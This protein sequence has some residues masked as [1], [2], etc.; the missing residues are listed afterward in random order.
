[1]R[2]WLSESTQGFV[3]WELLR[4]RNPIPTTQVLGFVR[5]WRS[6]ST[7]GFLKWEFQTFPWKGVVGLDVC[8]YHRTRASD[9]AS[10]AYD[11]DVVS[12]VTRRGVFFGHTYPALEE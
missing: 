7:Q 9:R 2:A 8:N 6:E 12:F 11:E 3:K 4:L 5:A 10:T 1:M